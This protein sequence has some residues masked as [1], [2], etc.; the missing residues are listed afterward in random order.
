MTMG[1]RVWKRQDGVGP[2]KNGLKAL[3]FFRVK[4][5]QG[6]KVWDTSL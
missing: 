1:G 4:I 6:L 3:R 2:C 5:F